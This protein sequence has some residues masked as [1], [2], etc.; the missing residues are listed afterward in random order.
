MDTGDIIFGLLS[1]LISVCLMA[2]SAIGL[3]CLNE[4]KDYGNKKLSNKNFLIFTVVCGG[5]GILASI[6]Y[7][8]MSVRSGGNRFNNPYNG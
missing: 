6:G 7:M 5:L 3:Q 8:A 4:N 2:T 1:L